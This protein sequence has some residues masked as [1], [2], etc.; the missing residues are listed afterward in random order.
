[1]INKIKK[2]YWSNFKEYD[3]IYKLPYHNFIECSSINKTKITLRKINNAY[4]GIYLI[5][6]NKPQCTKKI[7]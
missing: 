3:R 5:K 1:M 2:Y 4:F 6:K 7:N